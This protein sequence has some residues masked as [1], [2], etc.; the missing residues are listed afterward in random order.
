MRVSLVAAAANT[1][2]PSQIKEIG[3]LEKMA[4]DFQ[5]IK[6]IYSGRFYAATLT[7]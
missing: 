2:V 7:M 3:R 6:D 4:V 1:N 5:P